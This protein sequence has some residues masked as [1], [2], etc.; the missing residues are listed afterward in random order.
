MEKIVYEFVDG[1]KSE[2]IVDEKYLHIH[3]ELERKE[4]AQIQKEI[5][6]KW[7]GGYRAQRDFSLDRHLDE[8]GDINSNAETPLEHLLS[9]EDRFA[10]K[11]NQILGK[12]QSEVYRMWKG[13]Y[14]KVEIAKKLGITESA[15]RQR[16]KKA[17]EQILEMFE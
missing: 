6:Q 11:E 7:R 9:Q 2:V 1:T 12:K 14:K 13:G 10:E 5:K 8:C 17:E 16:I 4:R 15:V 3:Q